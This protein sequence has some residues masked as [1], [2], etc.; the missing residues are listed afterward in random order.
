MPRVRNQRALSID[1]GND[2][3]TNRNTNPSPPSKKS[4]KIP[5]ILDGRFFAI[6]RS[7]TSGVIV[8]KCC[9]CETND[10]FIHG[11]YGSTG[12]FWEHL[13]RVHS[14]K[15]DAAKQY[16]KTNTVPCQSHIEKNEVSINILIIILC[17]CI[18]CNSFAC[19]SGP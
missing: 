13:K 12:N 6:V 8:A 15:M 1:S 14:D 7:D 18:H 11:K 3:F 5:K 10:K 4:K 17:H 2:F 16:I 19:I 9:L